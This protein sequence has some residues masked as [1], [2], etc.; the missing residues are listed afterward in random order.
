MVHVP[1]Y[2]IQELLSWGSQG[3]VFLARDAAGQ[4]VA[5]KIVTAD[6]G[7]GDPHAM[8]RLQREARLLA[9]VDSPHVV[10]VRDFLQHEQW[11]CLVMEFLAGQRLDAAIRERRGDPAVPAPVQDAPTARLPVDEADTRAA[12]KTTTRVVPA[13]LQRHEHVA[14]ALDIAV[15]LAEGVATLHRNGLLHRDLKPHNVMLVDGRVVLIDFGFARRDGI[16]TLTQTGTAIG[17]LAYMSPEQFGG[18][19]AS[20]RSDVFALGA[21][22]HHCLNGFPPGDGDMQSL[23]ALAARRTPPDVR[24]A[25]PAVGANLARVVARCLEPDPRDR[26]PDAAAVLADLQRCRRLE[27]IQSSFSPGRAWRHHGRRALWTVA[28][29]ALLAGIAAA[30]TRDEALGIANAI[31]GDVVA[32]RTEAAHARWL[33]CDAECRTQVVTALNQ[34]LAGVAQATAVA[35]ALRL[36]MLGVT[37]RERHV[38]ALVANRDDDAVVP[39]PDAFVATD[40]PRGLLVQPGRAWCFVMST[41]PRH[42]WSPTD[43]RCLQLLLQFDPVE[44]TVPLRSLHALPTEGSFVD[45][46]PTTTVAAGT[47][48]VQQGTAQVPVAIELPLVVALHECDRS[49][50]LQFR[51]VMSGFRNQQGDVDAWFRHPDEPAAATAALW[52]I[53]SDARTVEVDPMPARVDFWEA[54]RLA[55]FLGFRLPHVR[56]WEVIAQEGGRWLGGERARRVPELLQPVDAVPEWDRTSRGVCFATSN[57]SEWI[58]DRQER[59]DGLRFPAAP[60]QLELRGERTFVLITLL[61]VPPDPS[62]D[63]PERPSYRPHGLRLYRHRLQPHR[64]D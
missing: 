42:W 32:T 8:A 40:E 48:P 31:L 6:R 33:E 46:V 39:S 51:R 3:D 47:Y 4:R 14:W 58:L 22:I 63:S 34:R 21:T 28:A 20:A 2:E 59:L 53:W 64:G 41:E 57:A 5:L 29:V 18:G 55:A 15:Q 36:G 13:A 7:D 38:I 9:A 24:R 49:S 17:T 19:E 60:L 23:A 56:E 61:G 43:P 25:N 30:W 11:S 62:Q 10:K 52:A 12:T 1:G 50:L 54:H 45:S 26:H 27:A 44:D 16:T 37:K 35:R